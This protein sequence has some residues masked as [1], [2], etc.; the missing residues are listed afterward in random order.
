MP[1]DICQYV[2]MLEA[3]WEHTKQGGITSTKVASDFINVLYDAGWRPPKIVPI[4]EE[5]DEDTQ[6]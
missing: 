4:G 1:A 6:E 5:S 3:Q 2:L